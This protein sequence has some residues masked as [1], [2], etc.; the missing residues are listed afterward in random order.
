MSC[1]LLIRLKKVK[2]ILKLLLGI[3]V[4]VKKTGVFLR[5]NKVQCLRL[6]FDCG[7]VYARNEC[8]KAVKT[9]FA[10]LCD[11]DFVFTDKTDI[12]IPL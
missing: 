5:K 2:N 8:I 1:I 12:N 4:E 7:V 6:L 9:K 3:K 11:D 10:L